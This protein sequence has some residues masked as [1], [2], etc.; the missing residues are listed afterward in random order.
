MPMNGGNAVIFLMNNCRELIPICCANDI[1]PLL[2][3]AGQISQYDRAVTCFDRAVST[4][5]NEE[6]R[7][8]LDMARTLP[9]VDPAS[10]HRIKIPKEYIKWYYTRA[11]LNGFTGSSDSD[12]A[13]AARLLLNELE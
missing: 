12:K 6:F 13:A 2:V 1:E 9:A 7:E 11:F 4:G 10:I 5:T 8:L 3:A